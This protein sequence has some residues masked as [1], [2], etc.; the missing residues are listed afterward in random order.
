MAGFASDTPTAK[1]V[2]LA[3]SGASGVVAGL[4]LPLAALLVFLAL[5]PLAQSE[6]RMDPA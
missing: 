5:K 6:R 2:V 3:L 4:V 1:D